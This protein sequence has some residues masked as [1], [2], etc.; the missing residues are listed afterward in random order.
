MADSQC[1]AVFNIVRKDTAFIGCATH[2]FDG[3]PRAFCEAMAEPEFR[4]IYR[5]TIII[6]NDK[7]VPD[8]PEFQM[9]VD[10]CMIRGRMLM[11]IDEAHLLCDP[12][13]IPRQLYESFILGRHESLSICY[14]TQSL[15][16]MIY[17]L[18]RKDTDE[19]YFWRINDPGD[20]DVI[21][22][23]CGDEVSE[24]VSNLRAL[25]DHRPEGGTVIPGEYVHWTKF[26]G[27]EP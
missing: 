6:R 10:A 16:G 11:I 2:V 13:H 26:R 24:R 5:P 22:E 20:L 7:G 17:P 14:I 4:I 8:F 23:M 12:Y 3:T 1:A 9:F 18:M 25:E 27:I 19:W 15:K 21:R